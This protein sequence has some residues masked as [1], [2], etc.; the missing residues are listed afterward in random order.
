MSPGREPSH[1][2]FRSAPRPC[3]ARR[4]RRGAF[5]AD[6]RPVRIQLVAALVLGLVLVASGLYLWRRPH[7]SPDGDGRRGPPHSARAA[8]RTPGIVAVVVD[9][10]AGA[11]RR[12]P[13]RGSS[14]ATTAGRRRRRRTQ[15]DHVA[16]VEQALRARDRAVGGVRLRR[17]RTARPSNTSPTSASRGTRCASACR[18]GAARCTT[19]RSSRACATA[20]REAMHAR[21]ARR[22]EHEH[23][24]YKIAV[25][26]TYR[27]HG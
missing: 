9:A 1:P 27:G 15:C 8:C 19:A 10:G 17:R 16:P 5:A 25:T 7:A 4:E 24:R 12:S 26:A 20:V 14:A 21:G 6:D 13:R 2:A 11:G 23:A 3:P 18:G 22:L